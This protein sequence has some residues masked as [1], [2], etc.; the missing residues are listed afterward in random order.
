MFVTGGAVKGGFFGTFPSLAPD[1]LS[2]G[3]VPFT[4]D[5]REVYAT[6]L[7]HWLKADDA[8]ILG[9]AYDPMAFLKG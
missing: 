5:F 6:I 1:K 3:D 8:S 2:R 9:G 7:R 4:A